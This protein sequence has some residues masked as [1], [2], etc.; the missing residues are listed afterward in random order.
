MSQWLVK[1]KNLNYDIYCGINLN[2]IYERIMKDKEEFI[3]E[4]VMSEYIYDSFSR[5]R[6][7]K[8][9][10][11]KHII[12]NID[13]LKLLNIKYTFSMKDISNTFI[14]K[15]VSTYFIKLAR[16][17][18]IKFRLPFD[19]KYKYIINSENE[20]DA[21]KK[22]LEYPNFMKILYYTENGGHQYYDENVKK[23]FINTHFDIIKDMI[24]RNS[25][26]IKANIYDI[27]N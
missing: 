25:I 8:Y 5:R 26:I 18:S 15:S 6:L 2:A 13:E 19:I 12:R 24:R 11:I 16:K 7:K 20:S 21:L 3:T 27:M 17:R 10:K 9:V 23:E 4:A 1:I 14:D 22:L